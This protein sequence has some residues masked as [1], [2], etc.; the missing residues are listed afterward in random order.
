MR[1]ERC[2]Q[3]LNELKDRLAFLERHLDYGR[4]MEDR[5][6]R[7]AIYKEFQ[8]AVEVITDICAIIA[9]DMGY[10]IEDDYTNIE[11]VC[12]FAWVGIL[13]RTQTCSGTQECH[14]T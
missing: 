14:R 5:I 9:K 12:E 11:R 8:E 1:K 13:W 3:K 2:L 7:K 10:S 4:F 6:L